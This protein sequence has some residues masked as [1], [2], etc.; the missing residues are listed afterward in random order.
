MQTTDSIF[1][2]FMPLRRLPTAWDRISSQNIKKDG[3][4]ALNR[5]YRMYSSR[6]TVKINSFNEFVKWKPNDSL[7]VLLEFVVDPTFNPSSKY[8]SGN[9][10]LLVTY[11]YSE[12]LKSQLFKTSSAY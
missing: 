7:N 11:S 3:I 12:Q 1:L 6:D 8:I 2:L 4:D 9:S 5:K 10:S